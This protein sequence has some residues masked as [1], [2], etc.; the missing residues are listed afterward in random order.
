MVECLCSIPG[1]L[2]SISNCKNNRIGQNRTAQNTTEYLNELGMVTHAYGTWDAEAAESFEPRSS[3]LAQT[4]L[5]N[6]VSNAV[7]YGGTYLYS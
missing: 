4:T 1:V 6:L 7:G 2:S 3:K 5:Q